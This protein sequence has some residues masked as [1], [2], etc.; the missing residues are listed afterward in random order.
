MRKLKC[1]IDFAKEERWLE[2]MSRK[3]YR[4]AGVG[5]GY[6]FVPVPPQEATVRVDCRMFH[7]KSDYAD[8]LALF[9]DSGWVHLAGSR[10]SGTQY[11]QKAGEHA[12]DDIFSDAGSKAERFRRLAGVWLGLAAVYLPLWVVQMTTGTVDAGAI[13]NPRLLYYTPGLWEKTGAA[14][15]GAF[16]FETPFAL[17]RGFGWLLLVALIFVYIGFSLKAHLLYRKAKREDAPH[18]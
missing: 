10:Y 1:F 12:Q 11:F 17:M 5:F 3:G 14:F 13:L 6:N 15:W 7:N 18:P 16:L 2:G 4:L 9:E 8:Y